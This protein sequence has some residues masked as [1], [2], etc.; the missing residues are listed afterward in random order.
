MTY[1]ITPA[2]ILNKDVFGSLNIFMKPPIMSCTA[3]NTSLA[4]CGITTWTAWTMAYNWKSF[5]VYII[6]SNTQVVN[7][8]KTINRI[9]YESNSCWIYILQ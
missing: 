2:P 4:A 6:I 7:V 5:A 3:L 9:S 1:L 8:L